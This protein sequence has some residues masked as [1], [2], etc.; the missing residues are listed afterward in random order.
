MRIN[1]PEKVDY[2]PDIIN[3]IPNSN[4]IDFCNVELG[5]SFSL[6]YSE[7]DE[8]RPVFDEF[9]RKTGLVIDEYGDTRLIIDNL[10]LIKDIAIDY[11]KKEINKETCV[12]I[13]SFIKNL[14]MITK[15]GYHFLVSGD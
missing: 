6:K 3:L 8:L 1:R 2:P 15:G 4:M 13:Q 7:F 11:T 9:Y 12:L 14:E 10:F 5:T